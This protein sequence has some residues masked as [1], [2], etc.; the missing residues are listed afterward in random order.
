M[1]E[2]R[3]SSWPGVLEVLLRALRALSGLRGEMLM[4]DQEA[5]AV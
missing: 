5:R 4:P 1:A 2:V 3:R